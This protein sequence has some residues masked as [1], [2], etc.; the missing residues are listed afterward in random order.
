LVIKGILDPADAERCASIGCD[1]II[2]SNHGGRQLDHALSPLQVL[3]EIVARTRG[4]LVVMLDSGVRR[5]V[6]ILK[7]LALGADFVFIGRPAMY[8]SAVAGQI[9]IEHLLHLLRREVDIALA[10]CGCSSLCELDAG[11]VLRRDG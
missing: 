10:L 1:G 7:A 8:A 9:G 5:G 3:P 2:V 6:D 4:N 11:R